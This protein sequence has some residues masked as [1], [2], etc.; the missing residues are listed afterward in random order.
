MVW[1]P[2]SLELFWRWSVCTEYKININSPSP[3]LPW[4]HPTGWGLIPYATRGWS[5]RN[6]KISRS[7]NVT[8]QAEKI[9]NCKAQKFFQV[10]QSL[11]SVG[12][13]SRIWLLEYGCHLFPSPSI[14][15]APMETTKL[16]HF[17]D[18]QILFYQLVYSQETLTPELFCFE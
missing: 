8:K 4:P 15:L 12:F 11:S 17:P 14:S 1:K 2:S 16:E 5:I 13:R 9:Q 7:S 18:E 10:L 3:A 6:S